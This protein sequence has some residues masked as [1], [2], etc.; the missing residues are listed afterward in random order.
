MK[1]TGISTVVF[2][3][4]ALTALAQ[5]PAPAPPASSSIAKSLGLSSFPAKGQT[6]QQQQKDE[7]DCY[8][9]AKGQTNYDPKA[10]PQTTAAAPPPA[11]GGAVK[12][13]A[14]GAAAGAVVGGVADDPEK[15]AAVGA[16]AGA[17]KGRRTQKKA[18]AQAEKDTQAKQQATTAQLDQY[19]KAFSSCLEGKGYTVK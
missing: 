18:N 5:T 6:A 3:L 12:G 11:K 1:I 9:W 14:R 7:S 2:G 16:T 19:K 4:A 10:P 15:G 13:A 17:V 8:A